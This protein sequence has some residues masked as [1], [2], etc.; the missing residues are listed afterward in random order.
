MARYIC[1]ASAIGVMAMRGAIE[2]TGEGALNVLDPE[3]VLR[4]RAGHTVIATQ[5]GPAFSGEQLDENG[6]VS[7]LPATP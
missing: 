3:G 4:F 7:T 6:S 5:N 2:S 1:P